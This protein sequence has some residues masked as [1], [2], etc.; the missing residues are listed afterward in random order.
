M[1]TR[2]EKNR[3]VTEQERPCIY[4]GSY[5]P[6][7]EVLKIYFEFPNNSLRKTPYNQFIVHS[8]LWRF[9]MLTSGQTKSKTGINFF[10]TL[11][12]QIFMQEQ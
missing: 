8:H 3:S 4:W 9:F 6:R 2:N 5:C 12:I 1:E 7:T 10:S 11:E